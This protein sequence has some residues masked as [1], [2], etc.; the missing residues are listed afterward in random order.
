MIYRLETPVL[1][2]VEVKNDHGMTVA[3]VTIGRGGGAACLS[4]M[5]QGL[6]ADGHTVIGHDGEELNLI[7]QGDPQ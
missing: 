4:A 3:I 6:L 5:V 1:G 7:N 2:R